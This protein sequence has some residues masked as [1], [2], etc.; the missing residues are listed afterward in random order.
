MKN[1]NLSRIS[2][3]LAGRPQHRRDRM[4]PPLLGTPHSTRAV[5]GLGARGFCEDIDRD[6]SSG[7][8]IGCAAGGSWDITRVIL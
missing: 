3:Y 4:E 7:L 1:G 5:L 8:V 2:A 6:D